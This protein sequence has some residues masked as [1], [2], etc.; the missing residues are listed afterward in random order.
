ML[1]GFDLRVEVSLTTC[2]ITYHANSCAN[3]SRKGHVLGCQPTLYAR[4]DA[5]PTGSLDEGSM[6]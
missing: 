6:L 2:R 3:L 5:P 1:H 4:R